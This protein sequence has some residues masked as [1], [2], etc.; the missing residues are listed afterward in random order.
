LVP[1]KEGGIIMKLFN[2]VKMLC[3]GENCEK[4]EKTGIEQT[5]SLNEFFN[6]LLGL[7]SGESGSNN[8]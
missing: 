4:H 3:Y 5:N 2:N 7:V 6:K 1:K 8:S